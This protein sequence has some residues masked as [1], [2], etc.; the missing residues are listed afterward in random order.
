MRGHDIPGGEI[1]QRPLD[2]G[3]EVHFVFKAKRLL[4]GGVAASGV[5]AGGLVGHAPDLGIKSGKVGGQFGK[6]NEAGE[7]AR[8]PAR[9]W[10][11]FSLNSDFTDKKDISTGPQGRGARSRN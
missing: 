8:S 1:R 11:R 2:A 6:F 3:L 9:I 10:R 5:D 4:L 7:D